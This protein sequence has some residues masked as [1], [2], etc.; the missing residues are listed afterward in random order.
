MELGEKSKDAYFIYGMCLFHC[1]KYEKSADAL[2]CAMEM[3]KKD[4]GGGI[5]ESS[6]AVLKRPEVLPFFK[7][8]PMYL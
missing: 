3:D 2:S 6:L 8:H 4:G 1:G 7:Q 5:I